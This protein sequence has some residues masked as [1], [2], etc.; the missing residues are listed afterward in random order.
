MVELFMDIKKKV[1]ENFKN[2]LILDEWACCCIYFRIH[3]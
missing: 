2:M 1:L 3:M